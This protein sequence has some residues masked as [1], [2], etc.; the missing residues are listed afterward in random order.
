LIHHTLCEEKMDQ[1]IS[2]VK[3]M[4]QNILHLAIFQEGRKNFLK[5]KRNLKLI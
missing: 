3:K 4:A 1:K 5:S 2:F